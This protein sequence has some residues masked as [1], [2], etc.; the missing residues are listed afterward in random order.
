MEG[1]VKNKRHENILIVTASYMIAYILARAKKP[2]TDG[3]SII[4]IPYT[5]A[6]VKTILGE[7]KASL[8]SKI[9]LSPNTIKARTLKLAQYIQE[10]LIKNW[11]QIDLDCLHSNLMNRT[12]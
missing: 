9:P 4:T 8:C 10:R 1:K 3:E 11:Y 7:E 12:T 6:I 5:Q 2:Y